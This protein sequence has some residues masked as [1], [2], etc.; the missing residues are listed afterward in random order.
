MRYDL[1]PPD[2]R[3]EGDGRPFLLYE[4]EIELGRLVMEARSIEVCASG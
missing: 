1:L 2:I 3:R 4:A